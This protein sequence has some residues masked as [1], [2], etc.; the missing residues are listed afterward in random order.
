M[1][2]HPPHA[3]TF[4]EGDEFASTDVPGARDTMVDEKVLSPHKL[5]GQQTD[6]QRT[7]V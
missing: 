4:L 3:R 5:A 6:T 1:T 2:T 7:P